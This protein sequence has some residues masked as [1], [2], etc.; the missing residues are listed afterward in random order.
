[1]YPNNRKIDVPPLRR[2]DW[3]KFDLQ[4]FSKHKDRLRSPTAASA[5]Y[6]S[7]LAYARS[8]RRAL[9]TVIRAPITPTVQSL[10]HPLLPV[11]ASPRIFKSPYPPIETSPQTAWELIQKPIQD[12]PDAPA[13][14]C[15]AS[16]EHMTFG[17]FHTAVQKVATSLAQ[18]GVSKG[19]VV[20]T[21]MIN[22]ME[23]PILYH[24]LTALGAVLSPAP[25]MFTAAELARQMTISKASFLVTHNA[26]EAAMKEAAFAYGIASD[27]C[28]AAGPS[29]SM[30]RFSVLQEVQD[31]Q[32]PHVTIDPLR[33]INYLPFSSGTTGLPKGVKLSFW[34]LAV[35]MQ[36]LASMEPYTSPLILVLPYYHIYGTMLLNTS[37]LVGQPQVIL[38]KFDPHTFLHAL[39][40]YKIEKAHVA[41]PI[42][43]L[44]AKHP[45]IDNFDLSAT[46][47]FISGAAPLGAGLE[48]AIY[49]RLGIKIKQ[50]YGMTELSPLSNYSRDSLEKSGASGHLVPGTELRVVCPTTQKDLG[51]NEVGE[52]WIRGP[53][54]MLGYLDNDKATQETMAPC[55]FL[56]TGD[57]G[58]IGDEG[59]VYVVDRLKELIKYKGRQVAPA[60]LED[61][62]LK[63][64]KVFDVACIRG[65]TA[66]RDEFP[67]A[68]VVVQ[69]GETL[70]P[71]ELME[72][73]AG[74]V[75]SFK[76]IRQ[77][78]FVPSIPKSGSG[79]ILRR[80]LQALYS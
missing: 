26:V 72:F 29:T 12:K 76:K 65:Y 56:K 3:S 30:Q 19:D 11:E 47:Y 54:V 53:Q 50:G 59:H 63:H 32:V 67:M 70:T 49:D 64:P 38:P 2:S 39:Q 45:D 71:E 73:V 37:L 24:A 18:R 78:V 21:N 74:Q 41:P 69:P 9:T 80:E 68:C 7:M 79:K 62:M 8:T 22:C 28:F 16:H 27:R 42:V 1:M 57:L 60:E 14:V 10:L 46:K 44:L 48:G 55:G 66:D 4:A 51:P 6:S 77:V 5:T 58:Y 36:Q 33:D 35:N 40:K 20:L 75:A 13:L 61:L 31:I 34:N 43:A 23:F 25:P 17:E 52:L 15:G